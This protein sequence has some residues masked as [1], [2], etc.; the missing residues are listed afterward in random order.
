VIVDN[1]GHLC[2]CKLSNFRLENDLQRKCDT[3][4]V[5]G[6]RENVVDEVVLGGGERD[7]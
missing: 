7:L 4:D 3:A 5:D 2:R 6:R 1:T